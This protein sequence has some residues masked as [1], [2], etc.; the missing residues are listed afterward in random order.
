LTGSAARADNVTM[1]EIINLKQVRKARK[2]A[3][4]EREAETNRVRFGRTK[5]E[6]LRD[7]QVAEQARRRI[8]GALLDS[9]DTGQDD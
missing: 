4:A 1:A 2:R 3:S 7:D 8:D 6:R 9:R 5:G